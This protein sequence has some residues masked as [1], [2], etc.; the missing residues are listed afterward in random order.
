M[1]QW[2]WQSYTALKAKRFNYQYHSVEG[3]YF[4]LIYWSI[5]HSTVTLSADDTIVIFYTSQPQLSSC[6]GSWF[7]ILW[8]TWYHIWQNEPVHL[9]K[10]HSQQRRGIFSVLLT[11]GIQKIWFTELQHPANGPKIRFYKICFHDV[12]LWRCLMSNDIRLWWGSPFSGAHLVSSTQYI[13]HCS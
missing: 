10:S 1:V 13:L 5:G 2:L 11:Y 12:V 4:V 3:C 7:Y 6:S 9:N 8:T